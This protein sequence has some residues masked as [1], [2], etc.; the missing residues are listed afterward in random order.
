MSNKYELLIHC[1]ITLLKLLKPGGLK[2]VVAENLA[3]KQQLITINRTQ[4]RAPKLIDHWH[5]FPS[6]T[7]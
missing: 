3:L 6:D 4:K 1:T 5:G 2:K 7:D